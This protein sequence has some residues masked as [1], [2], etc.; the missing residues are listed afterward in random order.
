LDTLSLN[1]GLTKDILTA[2]AAIVIAIIAV[3]TYRRARDTVLRPEIIRRQSDLL[4]DLFRFL[5][6]VDTGH[7]S[8]P[9]YQGIIVLNLRALLSSY[10]FMSETQEPPDKLRTEQ[11]AGALVSEAGLELIPSVQVEEE[12]TPNGQSRYT[13]EERQNQAKAGIID[14]DQIWLTRAYVEFDNKL[15]DYVRDPLMP[16]QVS[17]ALA[18]LQDDISVNLHVHMPETLRQ[19]MEA[20]CKHYFA[21]GKKP[22]IEPAGVYTDFNRKRIRHKEHIEKIREAIREHLRVDTAW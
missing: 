2:L 17:T 21:G 18:K 14:I 13:R 22:V 6:N 7:H 4:S 19:F 8:D 12:I 5:S 16:S 9:D 1:V 20:F 10:G 11:P 3:L 15:S